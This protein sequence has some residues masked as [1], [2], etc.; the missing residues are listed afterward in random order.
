MVRLTN[1]LLLDALH[2]AGLHRLTACMILP[3]ATGMAMTLSLLS[4][5]GMRPTHARYVLWPR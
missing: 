2:L 1:L 4:L 3:L 5:R